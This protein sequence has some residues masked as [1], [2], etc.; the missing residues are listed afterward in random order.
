MCCALDRWPRLLP[1]IW[2]KQSQPARLQVIPRAS[3]WLQR[4][5]RG[6]LRGTTLD[7]QLQAVQTIQE[8]GINP[9]DRGRTGKLPLFLIVC[10]PVCTGMWGC[11]PRRRGPR[12]RPSTPAFHFFHTLEMSKRC[13]RQKRGGAFS[14]RARGAET[15]V[16]VTG[17][18]Q[19]A[20]SRTQSSD[21]RG[22]GP[23]QCRPATS[24]A[25][26]PCLCRCSGSPPTHQPVRSR[27]TENKGPFRPEFLMSWRVIS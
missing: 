15:G 11:S 25:R 22:G 19:T 17:V 9:C 3:H 16:D 24:S 27:G 14:R 4:M 13:S 23:Q 21:Y 20:G 2:G 18:E 8:G 5:E 6:V 12:R 1:E 7:L 26:E 10:F